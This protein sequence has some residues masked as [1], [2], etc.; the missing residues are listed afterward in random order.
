N[1]EKKNNFCMIHGPSRGI[2]SENRT[3]EDEEEEKEMV[4]PYNLITSLQEEHPTTS[5]ASPVQSLS[6]DSTTLNSHPTITAWEASWNVT[7]A[8]QGIFVLGLPF[9]LVQSGYMG[10][11]ILVLSAWVCNHTGRILVDCLYEEEHSKE[12]DTVSKVRVRHSY[13]DIMDACCKGL[14]PYW[15]VVGGWLINV[16]QVIELL[17]TCTLYLLVSTTLL[18][19]SLS[20]VALPRSACSL[21]SLMFLLPCLLL[22]DLKPVSTLSLLCSLAHILISLLV[23]LY[24]LSCAS[25]WSWASLS[26]SVDPEDFIVSV[27]VI[28]FS[29]TSQIFLPPL[30]GSMED[31]EQ[32]DTML[33]WTH[34]VA[35]IMKTTFSLLAV[36]TWGPKTSEVITDN[37]PPSLRPIVNLCLLAKALLSYPLPF[38]SA[39]EILQTCLLRDAPLSSSSK[40]SS[41]RVTGPALMVRGALVVSSYLLSMLVPRFSLL[42]GL[43]GSVTGAAMTLILPCLFH[44]KL[45]WERLTVQDR[46]IDVAILSLGLLCSVAGVICSLKGLLRDL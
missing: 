17:M 38:Y 39:A 34:G 35:C 32:F 42:M 5:L 12:S 7:N 25:N 1:Q 10:L 20:T 19:D 46:L 21:V 4:S 44:L 27:G 15:S 6:T 41:Q 26:L 43:T 45:Q 37:L 14:W 16:A 31:K 40:Q 36:L 8:I 9:A 23:I 30:E 29:Y 18:C 11:V 33:G 3:K 13:Q 24:C 22:T 2:L 28:I